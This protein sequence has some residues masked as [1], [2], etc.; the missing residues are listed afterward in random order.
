MPP[1]LLDDEEAVAVAIGLNRAAAGA[2]QGVEE[3]SVRALSKINQILPPRLNQRVA[4]LQQM[5]VSSDRFDSP[6]DAKAL[7]ALA[8][9]CRDQRT[10]TFVAVGMPIARH[11][12][13]KTVR[14]RLRIR[15]PPR[16]CGVKAFHR[17]RM[18]NTRER[19][20]S[21]EERFEPLPTHVAALTAMDQ[22]VPPQSA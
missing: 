8:D 3:A 15:L 16:M 14:A 7:T 4:A 13:H 21:V 9:V 22:H 6:V 10:L 1:L 20:P 2:I 12:P 5:V 18:Q 11:P 19:N 17:I